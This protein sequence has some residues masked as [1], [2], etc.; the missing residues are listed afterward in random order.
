MFLFFIQVSILSSNR[1]D[2]LLLRPGDVESAS[3]GGERTASP[4]L[5]WGT[6]IKYTSY[7]FLDANVFN[8][9]RSSGEG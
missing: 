6:Y 2:A 4:A 3:G 5:I 8:L 7:K 9:P 1:R